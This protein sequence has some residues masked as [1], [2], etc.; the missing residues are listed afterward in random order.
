[1]CV[2][3]HEMF[4]LIIMKMQMKVKNRAHKHDIN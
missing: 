2:C 1:M 3:I 4:G